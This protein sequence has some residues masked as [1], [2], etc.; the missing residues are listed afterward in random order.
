MFFN[1]EDS[2]RVKRNAAEHDAQV[3]PVAA[4]LD[5]VAQPCDLGQLMGWRPIAVMKRGAPR[6]G[7]IEAAA[8]GATTISSTDR[9]QVW[10]S[11][12]EA[13]E[14]DLEVERI[15]VQA[16][17]RAR[18]PLESGSDTFA[19]RGVLDEPVLCSHET[20]FRELLA[21]PDIHLCETHPERYRCGLFRGGTT[22]HKSFLDLPATTLPRPTA[23]D[24]GR[25]FDYLNPSSLPAI[26]PPTYQ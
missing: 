19:V 23:T 25:Q 24:C 6:L 13:S 9:R 7:A 4:V 5:I 2:A 15:H 10:N 12:P 14:L 21:E 3:P 20:R 11:S 18:P 16:R 26:R 17:G 1:P 22:K 8:A